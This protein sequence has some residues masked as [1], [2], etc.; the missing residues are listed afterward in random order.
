MSGYFE[1]ALNYALLWLERSTGYEI[2][3]IVSRH[4]DGAEHPKV[5]TVAESGTAAGCQERPRSE[6]QMI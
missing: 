3:V 1:T 4:L 2:C 5:H 6:L